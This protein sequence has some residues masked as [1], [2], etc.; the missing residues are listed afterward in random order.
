[1]TAADSLAGAFERAQQW[2]L[3][4][5]AEGP[6]VRTLAHKK[7]VE[8]VTELS[9]QPDDITEAAD[10]LIC[11]SALATRN[12]W[13]AAD[14]AAAVHTKVAINET[15]TW[16]RESENHPWRHVPASAASLA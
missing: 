3:D 15:R 14:L 5:A 7:I 16:T 4:L 2:V 13:T 10:V 6:D 12:G 9:K 8:E 1:M 11:L